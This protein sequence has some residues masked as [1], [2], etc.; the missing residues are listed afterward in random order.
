MATG[1]ALQYCL[2]GSQ[3]P[4]ILPGP[5][6]RQVGKARAREEGPLQP[7]AN[8]APGY[9]AHRRNQCRLT[10]GAENLV[11]PDKARQRPRRGADRDQELSRECAG[12]NI[13]VDGDAISWLQ[14]N[15][16]F[17]LSDAVEIRDLLPRSFEPYGV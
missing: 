10:A 9:I 2:G 4:H 16:S 15:H 6:S 3:W 5:V 11:L 17:S 12:R 14:V 8:R 7:N 13:G 1:I